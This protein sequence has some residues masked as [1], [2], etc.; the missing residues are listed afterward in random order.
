MI[1]ANKVRNAFRKAR[2]GVLSSVFGEDSEKAWPS[3]ESIQDY[4]RSPPSKNNQPDAYVDYASES[5][6]VYQ[7]VQDLGV[8]SGPVLEIGPNVGRSLQ[9]FFERGWTDVSGIEINPEAVAKMGAL[10]PEM[11]ARANILNMPVEEG[12]VTLPERHFELVFSKAVLL[13]IHP[14]SDWVFERMARVTKGTLIVIENEDQKS[15]KLFPRQYRPIFESHGMVQIDERR[16]PDIP[17][18]YIA[19]S[20]RH[21]PPD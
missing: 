14:D 16:L 1:K 18:S 9:T 7:L 8:A 5:A 2:Y 21:A 11:A 20:F 3:K 13:H 4:W 17:A 10:F 12:I 6:S 19:R 15:Y